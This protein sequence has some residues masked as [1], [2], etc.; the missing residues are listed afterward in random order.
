MSFLH[1]ATLA[2]ALAALILTPTAALALG[3]IYR[4]TVNGG[5][6]YSDT[7]CEVPPAPRAPAEKARSADVPEGA[8][9]LGEWRGQAQ[10]QLFEGTQW[11][12][13]AH[14]VVPITLSLTADGK[15]SGGSP[16]NGCRVL[17][18]W[19][20]G[21]HGTYL[22]LDLTL[23]HC[24]FAGLNQRYSGQISAT[25]DRHLAQLSL[26]ASNAGLLAKPVSAELKAT[27]H[28]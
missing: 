11:L 12:G 5:T 28:H 27:L 24:N 21:R 17:G 18:L 8:P 2:T 6:V 22:A 15:V 7:M 3:Q 16:D 26:S 10:Y 19:M 25:E 1:P 13:N 9:D 23:S 20:A 4:C 14:A